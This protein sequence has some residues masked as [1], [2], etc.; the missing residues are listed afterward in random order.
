MVPTSQHCLFEKTCGQWIS[1]ALFIR[2][3]V[4]SGCNIGDA[5]ALK[6]DNEQPVGAELNVGG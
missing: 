2:Q 1:G 3:P 4:K 5:Q 6:A